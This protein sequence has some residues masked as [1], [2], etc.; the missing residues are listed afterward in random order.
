M[1]SLFK[2]F[3][4]TSQVFECISQDFECTVQGLAHRL[5]AEEKKPTYHNNIGLQTFQYSV[6]DN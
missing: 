3:E 5:H 4:R 2:V 6:T 1:C